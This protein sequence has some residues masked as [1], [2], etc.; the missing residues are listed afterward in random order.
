[1]AERYNQAKLMFG[2]VEIVCDTFKTSFKKD[3]EEL[4]ACNST[5]PYD[6]KIKGETVEAEA[7][8]V[9]PAQRKQLKKLYDNDTTADLISYDYDEKTGDLVTDDF[10]KGAYIKEISKDTA[11]QPF[12]VK[13]GVRTH[14]KE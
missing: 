6:T 7:S 14:K 4:S 5:S 12:D 13:F 11:N 3:T 10:L 1:M 8:K 9:N 2:D